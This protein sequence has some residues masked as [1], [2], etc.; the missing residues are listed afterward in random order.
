MRR[1]LNPT[2]L[3]AIAQEVV[4]ENIIAN[5][6]VAGTED[7]LSS[8]E[9]AGT[10]YVVGGGSEGKQLYQHNLNIKSTD[11]TITCFLTIPIINDSSTVFTKDNAVSYINQNSDFMTEKFLPANGWYITSSHDAYL[12]TGIAKGVNTTTLVTKTSLHYN[13][14]SSTFSIYNNGSGISMD[15][16][17]ITL[18]ADN[19]IEL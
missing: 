8:I 2:E 9:I 16:R 12:V 17:Y 4:E 5:P 18:S 11:N 6:E 10:K 7:A 1:M 13:T 15:T 19:V 14:T 3:N